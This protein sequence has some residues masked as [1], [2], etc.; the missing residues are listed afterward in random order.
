[1]S[2]TIKIN[3]DER[4]LQNADPHWINS[5]INRRRSAGEVVCV[6]VEIHE[7]G[8]DLRL[9]TVTCGSR[10]GGGRPAN[11]KEREVIDLWNRL[12]LNSGEFTGGEVVAFVNQL[13]RLL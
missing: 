12:N 1:M 13:P 3:G 9:A 6:R 7:S 2:A 5:Q 8:V 11:P 10:G 4:E